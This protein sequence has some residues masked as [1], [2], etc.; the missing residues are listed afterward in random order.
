MAAFCC[1]VSTLGYT[2]EEPGAAQDY[3]AGD[4][5]GGCGDHGAGAEDDGDGDDI[6]GCAVLCT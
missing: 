3:D 6:K 1:G 2:L 5:D 4:D